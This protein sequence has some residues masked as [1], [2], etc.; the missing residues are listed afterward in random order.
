VHE[1]GEAGD[2]DDVAAA[3]LLEERLPLVHGRHVD[4]PAGRDPGIVDQHV[5]A[6]PRVLHL[7]QH[8]RPVRIEPNVEGP[9]VDTV[10]RGPAGLGAS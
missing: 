1:T 9:V 2:V 3:L 8:V 10:R 4:P 5:E 7:L 6:S